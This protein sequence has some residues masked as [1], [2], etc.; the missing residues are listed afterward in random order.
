MKYIGIFLT[1]VI[2]GTVALALWKPRIAG[3]RS[4]VCTF[5]TAKRSSSAITCRMKGRL[6]LFQ[7]TADWCGACT[8]IEPY[9]AELVDHYDF[10]DRKK[11]DIA[12]WDS[13]AAQQ[14]NAFF[15]ASS[16]PYFAL[17]NDQGQPI[18][19]GGYQQIERAIH[20]VAQSR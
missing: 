3:P 4:R 18:A 16:I 7:Y 12:S 9:V 10:L 13:P 15:D 6:V 11:I 17:Y 14:M 1:I 2:L 5:R 19:I 8:M 20:R